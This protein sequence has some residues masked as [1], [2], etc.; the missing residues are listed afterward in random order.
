MMAPT[1]ELT[2]KLDRFNPLRKMRG[3]R[4][5][6]VIV[7]QAGEPVDCVWMNVS[8]I[9]KNLK[10]FGEDAGL[11]EALRAYGKG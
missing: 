8:D 10:E 5:A 1:S 2:F 11:R 3:A 4:A 7:L 6:S 9:R